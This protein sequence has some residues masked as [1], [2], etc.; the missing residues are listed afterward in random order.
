MILMYKDILTSLNI[1][2]LYILINGKY[3][4]FYNH[5]LESVINLI[6]QNREYELAVETI[7]TDSEKALINAVK[8]YFPNIRRI[9]CFF[10]YKQNIIKNIKI[11][12]YIKRNT[13]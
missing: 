8:K 4:I 11:M 3:E 7:V 12:V 10:H 6:T 2:A 9:A 1:P 13:K 5:I